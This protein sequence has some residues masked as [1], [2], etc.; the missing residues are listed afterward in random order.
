MIPGQGPAV[1][2]LDPSF[3]A[4][5]QTMATAG[6]RRGRGD[7]VVPPGRVAARSMGMGLAVIARV[8]S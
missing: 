1:V 8:A 6:V 7:A 5:G 3:P 2:I 4:P